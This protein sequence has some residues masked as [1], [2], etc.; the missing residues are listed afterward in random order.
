MKIQIINGTD[1][2]TRDFRKLFLACAKHEGMDHG[3]TYTVELYYPRGGGGWGYYNRRHMKI[4]LPNWAGFV[5]DG[6]RAVRTRA[7][8]I[9]YVIIHEMCHNRG[10]RHKEM[11]EAANQLAAD[12][13]CTALEMEWL[14]RDTKAQRKPTP[15]R[16]DKARAELAR[17]EEHIAEL[18]KKH[19]AA[20]KRWRKKLA[21]AKRSVNYYNNKAAAPKKEN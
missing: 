9:A 2:S 10:L 17:C 19:A 5:E 13:V 18:Q 16:E 15:T 8:E 11:D 1:W 7:R 14:Q 20:L 4:A 21:A 12:E 6:K 3:G